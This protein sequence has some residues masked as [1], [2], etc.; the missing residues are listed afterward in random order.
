MSNDKP[1]FIQ[2]EQDEAIDFLMNR[3]AKLQETLGARDQYILALQEEVRNFNKN[4]AIPETND[5]ITG[6][7][8]SNL[9]QTNPDLIKADSDDDKIES[10]VPGKPYAP[11]KGNRR[12]SDTTVAL[13]KALLDNGVSVGD[14][15]KQLD[16]Q[17]GIIS[18]IR[19]G[20]TYREPS[21]LPITNTNVG[22]TVE[23]VELDNNTQEGVP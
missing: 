1:I 2:V 16:V 14:I 23:F 18:G 13:V 10:I 11:R 12:L 7:I 22:S 8:K 5:Y 17:P 21:P 9:P 4:L 6:V 15:S 19:A 3:I 20:Y